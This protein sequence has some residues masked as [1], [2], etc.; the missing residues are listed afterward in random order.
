VN[1][2]NR[3]HKDFLLYV[4]SLYPSLSQAESKVSDFLTSSLKLIPDMTVTEL[5]DASKVSEA[6]IVRFARKLGFSGYY[7]MKIEIIRNLSLGEIDKIS[8][9]EPQDVT[10]TKEKA[11]EIALAN[12]ENTYH[13]LDTRELEQSLDLLSRAEGIYFFAAGNTLNV[14]LDA[15]YKLGKLGLRTFCATVPERA[16]L[17]ARNMSAG[18][19]AFGISHS[20]GSKMVNLALKIAKNKGI[21]AIALSN[22]S[23]SPIAKWCDHVLLTST[24]HTLFPQ[25]PT[26]TRLAESAVIDLIFYLL[27]LRQSKSGYESI[28]LS[29]IDQSEYSL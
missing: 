13:A 2:K 18:D 3:E 5:A 21:P 8:E 9:S 27:L 1:L 12:I 11:L 22:Y 10:S 4:K 16:I 19:V 26:L 29:E 14:A 23:K 7:Q 28:S 24:Y 17:Q 6:S 15:S 20:G 25:V